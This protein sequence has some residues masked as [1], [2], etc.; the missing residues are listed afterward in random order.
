MRG[1]DHLIYRINFWL[2]HVIIIFLPFLWVYLGDITVWRFS[3]TLAFTGYFFLAAYH[4]WIL[5]IV[6]IYMGSNLNYTMVP[7]PGKKLFLIY[8]ASHLEIN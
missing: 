3:Y 6:S 7:P 8:L 4:A 2:E 1:R 5:P